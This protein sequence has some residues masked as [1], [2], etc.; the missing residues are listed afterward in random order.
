MRAIWRYSSRQR[1]QVFLI[2]VFEVRAIFQPDLYLIC[3]T[4][5]HQQIAFEFQIRLS[6]LAEAFGKIRTDRFAGSPHL[7]GET[8]KLFDLWEF[9]RRQMQI[10]RDLH[11][12]V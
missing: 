11:M 9:Q 1:S 10:E 4:N 5:R 8:A 7:I 6:L 3:G 12:L 2:Y